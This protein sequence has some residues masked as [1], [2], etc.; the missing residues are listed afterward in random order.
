MESTPDGEDHVS[1]EDFASLYTNAEGLDA[2]AESEDATQ[3]EEPL[4][5][6]V[7]ADTDFGDLPTPSG[8]ARPDGSA[9]AAVSDFFEV[10]SQVDH[11]DEPHGQPATDT[12]QELREVAS[13]EDAVDETGGVRP[14][15]KD[16]TPEVIETVETVTVAEEYVVEETVEEAAEEADPVRPRSAFSDGVDVATDRGET[17]AARDYSIIEEVSDDEIVVERVR[18]VTVEALEVTSDKG[19]SPAAAVEFNVEE[20]VTVGRRTEVRNTVRFCI[21]PLTSFPGAG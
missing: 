7:A 1:F 18:E 6:V 14:P 2:L 20:A 4:E 17:P 11:P 12:E 8:I 10:L 15:A 21:S 5:P 9:S 16:E 19:D 13:H 3:A